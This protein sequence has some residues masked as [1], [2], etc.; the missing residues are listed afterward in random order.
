MFVT[1]AKVRA[2]TSFRTESRLFNHV[3]DS[4]LLG[5]SGE[6]PNDLNYLGL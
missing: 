2:C 5:L 1:S 4:L 3:S 6:M